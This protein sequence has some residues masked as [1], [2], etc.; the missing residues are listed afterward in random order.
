[1]SFVSEILLNCQYCNQEF[2]K[3]K[4]DF[5][6]T[7]KH[8]CS[9]ICSESFTKNKFKNNNVNCGFCNKIIHI[10]EHM[11]KRS[12]SGLA[13]CSKKCSCSYANKF[14]KKTNR[15]KIEI[16]F[17]QELQKI[18]PKLKFLFNDKTI[19]NG[20]E[21][22]IYIPELKLAIEWNGKIHYYPIYGE[23]KLAKTQYRDHQKTLLCQKQD[24][25]LIVIADLKSTNKI[26]E[27][28]LNKVKHIICNLLNSF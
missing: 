4:A 20:Y 15:S 21:L 23:E 8:F 18:F 7:K 11:L 16:K 2:K 1:M 28:A 3:R 24:I 10:Q 6:R 19:I 5:K 22:D 27:D 12:K 13:F 25:D 14:R 26:L 17:G 9:R